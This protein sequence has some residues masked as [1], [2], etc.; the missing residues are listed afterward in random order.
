MVNTKTAYIN[1]V[2]ICNAFAIP[3]INAYQWTGPNGTTPGQAISL[4]YIGSNITY[5][6]VVS[7]ERGNAS[8]SLTLNVITP[9]I[10]SE[11]FT[12]L[13]NNDNNNDITAHIYIARGF[14]RC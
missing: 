11:Y 2:L 4:L 9:S 12:S 13:N 1:S 10:Y 7:N 6:C 3:I 5:T 14:K 8:L